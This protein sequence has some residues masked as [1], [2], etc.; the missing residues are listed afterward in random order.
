MTGR[1][2]A[3]TTMSVFFLPV[4]VR[5]VALLAVFVNYMLYKNVAETIVNVDHHGLR[6]NLDFETHTTTGKFEF[7]IHNARRKCSAI[8]MN[9]DR[10]IEHE[11]LHCEL[12]I[13]FDYAPVNSEYMYTRDELI[14]LKP[15]R[16][17]TLTNT[18]LNCIKLN[19]ISARKRGRRGGKHV[20]K[21]IPF[22]RLTSLKLVH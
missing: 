1:C 21:K 6:L 12:P 8:P 18:T 5:F 22:S 2:I 3:A 14:A 17:P 19:G 4:Y 20:G 9:K 10:G 15:E 16:R 7:E 11:P 13:R